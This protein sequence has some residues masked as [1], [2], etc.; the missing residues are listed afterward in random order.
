MSELTLGRIH[1]VSDTPM[2]VAGACGGALKPGTFAQAAPGTIASALPFTLLQALDLPL[3]SSGEG[4]A[5]VSTPL[6]ELLA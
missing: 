6:T 3:T 1:D 4:E 5:Q 2:L